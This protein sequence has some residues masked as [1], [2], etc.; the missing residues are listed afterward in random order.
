VELYI[1]RGKDSEKINKKIFNQ[2]FHNKEAIESEFGEPL[3]W[4]MLQGKRACRIKK[5]IT[6]GGYRNDDKWPE[7][8]E[9]MIY[10][11]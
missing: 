8:H 1:N 6:I 3:E 4:Q 9:A 10:S 7:I 5:C 2:L 11:I